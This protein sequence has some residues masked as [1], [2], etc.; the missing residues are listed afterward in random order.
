MS[1][2]L[3]IDGGGTKTLIAL[4]DRDGNVTHFSRG[5]GRSAFDNP[6][7][8]DSIEAL[9]DNVRA[10]LPRVEFAALAVGSYREVAAVDVNVDAGVSALLPAT[11]HEIEN[12]VFMAREAAFAGAAGIVLIAG[13]GSMA[14]AAD[15]DG[16][17]VR[18]GGWGHIF[19]DE[20]SSHWLGR[21]ALSLASQALDDRIS[22][23][24]FADGILAAI[25]VSDHM[26][27]ILAW[28]N[29]LE[30]PRSGIAAL[31]QA[32]S[33]LAAAGDPVATMLLEAA[34]DH[35]NRHLSAARRLAGLG[36]E[37]PWC[38]VGGMTRNPAVIRGLTARQGQAMSSPA[39]PPVG[40][41]LRRAALR[42]GWTITPGWISK[43]TAGLSQF[44]TGARA[45]EKDPSP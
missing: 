35:L 31:A 40:G 34:I 27:D 16:K 19:G 26:P 42:A 3:G 14:V 37:A 5:G 36:A 28:A 1:L 33:N 30:H 41:A 43:V 8:T 22:A 25:G 39:L 45:P 18:S 44:E 4:A 9:L 20:G 2:V 7:W 21:E 12:D 23:R 11:P 24:P 13:T 17:L 6:R 29:E 15:A 32:V 38:A 10:D